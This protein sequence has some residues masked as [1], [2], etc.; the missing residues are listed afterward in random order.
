MKTTQRF[1]YMVLALVAMGLSLW[2]C[3]ED[4]L[5]VEPAGSLNEAVL[6]TASGIDGLLI[7]AYAQLGGRGNYFSGASNW[8][9][10]SIAGGDANK[11][12]E[13]GDFADINELVTYQLNVES[14]I[15]RDR[16]NGIY[17]GIARANAALKLAGESTDPSVSDAFRTGAQAEGRFLRGHYYFQLKITFDKV[18]YLTE[19]LTP[20]EVVTTVSKD[21]WPD[22]EADLQFAFD[23]LP[24]TQSQAGRA[25]KTAAAAY[26]GKAF[27]YQGKWS[28]AKMMFD[29]VVD[30]GQTANGQRVALL[31][32]YSDVFNAEF[33]NSAESIFAV[34]AAANTGTTNNANPDFVLNFPHNTG[35]G[36]PGNCCGFFQ[37][38]FELVNSFRTTADGKPLLDGSYI[39]EG[40][41][42]V[43]DFGVGAA[44]D[45]TPD[46]GPLDPRLDHSV[47]RRGITYLDWGPFPGIAWIRDQPHAGPYAPKKF[48]YYRAQEN[49]LSDGT[50]WTRGYPAV[51]YNI[52]RYADVLL[53]LAEAEIELG[54]LDVGR[55]LINQVRSRA[56]NPAGFVQDENGDPAAN[57]VIST[58]DAPFADANE[59][60]EV[61]RFERKLELSGEG[62]RFFDLR[63]W[64]I[65]DSFLNYYVNYERQFLPVQFGDANFTSPQDLFYPIPQQQIDIQG[66]EFLPQNPGY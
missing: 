9:N 39:D 63:R 35:P 37:P 10:G 48:V 50:S 53:M 42:L 4:F 36:G 34:Q 14:R 64:G 58:Y 33:D 3:S 46:S 27:L 61:L 5:E 23:N 15:P 62:H 18:P 38:S 1:F 43:N 65:A 12:T 26:L 16:W 57:Y 7:G 8:A 29:W 40:N 13:T 22:I 6:S 51:N 24:A 66:A 54:N 28:Q 60:R 52:I 19:T 20:E 30:N 32:N 44:E 2:T 47:G 25:N 21:V 59:A 31:D 56:A 41:A 11:G 17:E 49:T 55:D 45:F